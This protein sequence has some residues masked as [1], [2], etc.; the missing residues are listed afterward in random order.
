M[1]PF[2]PKAQTVFVDDGSETEGIKERIREYWDLRSEGYRKATQVT[3]LEGEGEAIRIIG[4]FI[5]LNRR[6]KVADMGTGAGLFAILL[7]QH[8]HDV[9]AVDNS[10]RMLEMARRN[11][12]EAGVRIRFVEGDVEDPPLDKGSF[13]LVVSRNTVWTLPNP[14]KAYAAWRD[15][16]LPDGEMAIRDGNYYLDLYDEDYRRRMRYLESVKQGR[17]YGLHA[18]TNVGNVD[19]DIIREIARDLPMSRER[20]PAWDVAAL[21]GAGMT[22][23]H[24]KSLDKEQYS[25]LTENGIA[26]L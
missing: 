22:D 24:V 21:M 6:L 14:R 12:E 15:L 7:A 2:A 25:I 3:L 23:I 20:R 26:E 13:D 8:G 11:A 17:N 1:Q 18:Q 5:N 4:R 16:L 19:F 9:V 10:G